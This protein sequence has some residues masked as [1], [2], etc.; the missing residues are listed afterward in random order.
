MAFDTGAVANHFLELGERDGVPLSSMKLQKILYYAHGWHLALT[1]EPLLDDSI[2][3]WQYGPV[4]PS[5]YHEFKQFGSRPITSRYTHGVW[6]DGDV[7]FVAPRLNECEGN[8]ERAIAICD[9]VWQQF[10]DFTALQLST[11]THREGTPW[12]TVRNKPENVGRK[13]VDIHDS[14]I[15]GYF[16]AQMNRKS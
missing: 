1:G 16:K 6:N 10:K 8:T 5:I 15:S 7:A 3:A 14:D 2:E 9:R 13:G 4:I 12:F 11:M